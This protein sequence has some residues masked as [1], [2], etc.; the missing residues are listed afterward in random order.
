[1]SGVS[2]ET[3]EPLLVFDKKLKDDADEA[4]LLE[5]SGMLRTLMINCQKGGIGRNRVEKAGNTRNEVR[6]E[7]SS[8]VTDQRLTRWRYAL[9]C[10]PLN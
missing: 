9:S 4:T 10:R 1:M 2:S 3:V 8:V 5:G 6:M 7:S